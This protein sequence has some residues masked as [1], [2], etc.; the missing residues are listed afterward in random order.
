[1]ALEDSLKTEEKKGGSSNLLKANMGAC[2][3]FVILIIGVMAI[4][5]AMAGVFAGENTRTAG[6]GDGAEET[7]PS[8][9]VTIVP[10]SCSDAAQKV[11]FD[12]TNDRDGMLAG[13]E[14][15]RMDGVKITVDNRVCQLINTLVDNGFHIRVS[16]IVGHHSQYSSSGNES[17]HWTGHALDIGNEELCSTLEPWIVQNLSGNE[18]MPRQVIGPTRCS[19]WAVNQGQRSPG[20]YVE[21]H[22]DH[23]H[24]GF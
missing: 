14:I 3:C 19:D 21:G 24:I 1:M 6:E 18:L 5:P 16:S 10:G 7:G 9:P 11:S 20:F 12:Q 4:F 8:E 17:R 13:G 22:E 15:V 23:I 2:G